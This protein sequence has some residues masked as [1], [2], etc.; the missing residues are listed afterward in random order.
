M[1]TV[2]DWP[3]DFSLTDSEVT[4][5]CFD[6]AI[7]VS[8]VDSFLHYASIRIATPFTIGGVG[9][10]SPQPVDPQKEIASD[11]LVGLVKL[12]GQSVVSGTTDA[13][14]AASFAFSSGTVIIAPPHESFEAW[15]VNK[16]A[17]GEKWLAE[18][19]GGVAYWPPSVSPAH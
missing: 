15:D 16:N 9:N 18:P 6:A 5:V 4:R 8:V 10:E 3:M 7:T 11:A 1:E 14:G 2:I 13:D 12:L 17:T 19:G